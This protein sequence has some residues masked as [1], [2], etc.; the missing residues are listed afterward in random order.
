MSN[1]SLQQQKQLQLAA[2]KAALVAK[3]KEAARLQLLR[4]QCLI[5]NTTPIVQ[6]S[7]QEVI[8]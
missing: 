5:T 4:I 3:N 2:A 7:K 8:V 1:Y 6:K